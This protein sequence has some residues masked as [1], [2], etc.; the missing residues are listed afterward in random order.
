MHFFLAMSPIY[1]KP[2]SHSPLRHFESV[3]RA[4]NLRNDLAALKKK[5]SKARAARR[6][7]VPRS[8]ARE[9][10]SLAII[11]KAARSGATSGP[12]SA[13]NFTRAAAAASA[14]R[15]TRSRSRARPLKTAPRRYTPKRF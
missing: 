2:F 14:R 12:L 5:S 13:D 6:A 8:F 10:T 15:A 7:R 1:Q 4:N 11:V 3:N 9:N